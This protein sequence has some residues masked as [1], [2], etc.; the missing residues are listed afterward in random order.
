MAGKVQS[1]RGTKDAL[2][3]ETPKWRFVEGV[4]SQVAETY[5]FQEIRVPTIEKTELFARSVGETTDVVQKEMYTFDAGRESITLRPEGTAG[6]VR[7]VIQNGLLGDALPVKL[8]SFTSCFRRERP[9]AGRLREFH[10]FGLECFGAEAPSQDAEVI[11]LAARV[12]NDIGVGETELQMNSIGCPKCRPAYNKKL[13]DY[14]RGHYD[15]LCET[16]KGR[17]EKNPLRLL[18]CKEEQCQPFKADAPRILDNLCE[19]CVDHFE[20]VKRNLDAM[21]IPYRV[22][23]DIVRGLDYYTRTVFEFVSNKIGAQATVCG[24]GR[25]DG[26]VEQMG[27]PPTPGL[28]FAMGIERLLMVMEANGLQFGESRRCDLYIGSM[29]EE[30]NR[31]AL[32]L[33]DKL[34]AQGT[35][36]LVDTVGR[37]VKAQMKYA[38][39]MN[40]SCSFVIGGNELQKGEVG[41]KDMDSGETTTVKLD[42]AAIQKYLWDTRM[43]AAAGA[44]FTP[45]NI[46][47]EEIISTYI[48]EIGKDRPLKERKQDEE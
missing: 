16:C 46:P 6:I 48:Y 12:L 21:E 10:Q 34:R 7:A 38:N 15:D 40:A 8:Y 26:L 27:G 5:G 20:G 31:V 4:A 44:K 18:D 41:I 13:V 32:A 39:K 9:Q 1:L 47:E 25:Y 3:Q 42:A 29:G 36:V 22:N 33:A 11:A 14:Y 43:S 23:P 37:G 45:P 17:L 28:G 35:H 19:E 2:P 24:G 30:E